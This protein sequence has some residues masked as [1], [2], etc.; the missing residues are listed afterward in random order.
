MNTRQFWTTKK[1][2]VFYGYWMLAIAFFSCFIQSGCGMYGF[3]LFVGQ[4]QTDFGWTRS[5]I[6]TGFTAY[7]LMQALMGPLTGRLVD[8]YGASKT[9]AT[10][11]LVSGLGFVL[12]NHMQGIWTLYV[13][14][15]MVG[16]G[17]SATGNISNSTVVSNWFK[18]RRGTAMGIMSM[19]VGAGGLVLPRVI[20]GYLIPDFGWRTAYFV[21]A[22]LV[23]LLVP[24]ALFVLKTKPADKGLLSDGA[25][26]GEQIIESRNKFGAAQGFTTKR[27]LTTLT[28]WLIIISFL[29]HG[30]THISIMQ[31]QVS[32]LQDIGFPLATAATALSSVGLG[33]LFGKLFFGWLCDK[34]HA[35]YA[36]AIGLVLELIAIIMLINMTSTTSIVTIWVYAILL[37]FGMGA[38]LPTMAILI[39]S[40]FGLVSFGSLVGM[41]SMAQ[42]IGGSTGPVF[43]GRMYDTMH[44]YHQAFIIL[45]ILYAISI[46]AILLARPPKTKSVAAPVQ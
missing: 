44:T 32:H 24:L 36:F 8:R 23:W 29:V 42:N 2:Q 26:P 38:W 15:A 13:G 10:G 28:F 43:A 35:K 33:S 39:S 30:F 45:A 12:L 7:S 20:G 18:K 21:M 17:A 4:L 11:A 22:I 14:W 1:P 3:S 19:G 25:Q 46:P 31:T 27:A 37:G 6:L 40:N 5:A 16:I 9:I 41:I 34:I